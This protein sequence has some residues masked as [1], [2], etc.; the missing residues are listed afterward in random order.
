MDFK[1]DDLIQKC[2]TCNGTGLI[3]DPP[4]NANQGGYGMRR[5]GYTRTE[6]CLA[7][8]QSGQVLTEKGEAIAKVVELLKRQRR[9]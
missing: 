6:S 4:A 2:Q 9:I 3:E 8:H 5:V 1:V 7:C